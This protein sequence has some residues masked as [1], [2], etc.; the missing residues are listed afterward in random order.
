MPVVQSTRWTCRASSGAARRVRP[1]RCGDRRARLVVLNASIDVTDEPRTVPCDD[2]ECRSLARSEQRWGCDCERGAAKNP[3]VQTRTSAAGRWSHP[4][5][6][7]ER[8]SVAERVMFNPMTIQIA[9]TAAGSRDLEAKQPA[10]VRRHE[11]FVEVDQ[12]TVVRRRALRRADAVRVVAHRARGRRVHEV[13]VVLFERDVREN[14]R[15]VVAL[16]TERIRGGR[17]QLRAV[18]HVVPLG[19]TRSPLLSIPHTPANRPDALGAVVA[20]AWLACGLWQS[21]HSACRA[22]VAVVSGILKR[23]E[24]GDSEASCADGVTVYVGC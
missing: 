24:S 12:A 10:R 2:L 9:A 23:I 19:S 7:D 14:A 11:S 5:R 20:A 16:V 18:V 1:L 8:G 17:L 13:T 4:F 21:A 22:A 6:R 3:N 15:P